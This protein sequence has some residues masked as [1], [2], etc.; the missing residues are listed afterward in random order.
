[1][2]S[3]VNGTLTSIHRLLLPGSSP[4]QK[5]LMVGLSLLF[6]I[7]QWDA[8]LTLFPCSN[9]LSC[10]TYRLLFPH[11]KAINTVSHIALH[12]IWYPT[13]NNELSPDIFTNKFL[14]HIP[15]TW[16]WPQATL[17][18]SFQEVHQFL[19]IVGKC[20]WLFY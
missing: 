13:S 3:L 16:F 12:G 11:K 15:P 4:F 6:F 8:I 5:I 7:M 18:N 9:Y 19:S 2:T 1:M 17:H 20:G 10:N 14:L